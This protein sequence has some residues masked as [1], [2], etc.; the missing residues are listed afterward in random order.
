MRNWS[1][2][3]DLLEAD[4]VINLPIAKHHGSSRLTMSLK[5]IMGILGGNRGN[6]HHSLDLNIA[7]LNAVFMMN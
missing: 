7:E 4:K 5:N 2:H 1:F 3:R 6:I